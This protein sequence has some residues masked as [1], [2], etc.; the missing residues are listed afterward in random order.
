MGA[1][2]FAEPRPAPRRDLPMSE[3]S[4]PAFAFTKL[5]VADLERM[6]AFYEAAYGLRAVQRVRGVRIGEEEIDEIVLAPEPNAVWGSL[7]LLRFLGRTPR[8]RGGEGSDESN[9]VILG[10][11]T[12]DL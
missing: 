7:I 11:T 5:V 4:A 6:A 12:T 8:R 1:S 10:F 9:E 3:P 2:V